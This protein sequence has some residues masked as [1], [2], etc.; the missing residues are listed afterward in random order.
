MEYIS[1]KEAE[2]KW[3]LIPRMIIYYCANGHIEGAQKIGN[4]WIVPKD[5]E[6][7]EDRRK[8][9]GRRLLIKKL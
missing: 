1:V 9:N 4:V 7:P 8:G 3:G 2:D 5:A 6:R